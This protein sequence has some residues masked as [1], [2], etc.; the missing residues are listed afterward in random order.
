[1]TA[2]EEATDPHLLGSYIRRVY[3]LRYLWLHVLVVGVSLVLSFYSADTWWSR[4]VLVLAQYVFLLAFG[5]Y[6]WT[7]WVMLRRPDQPRLLPSVA[8]ITVCFAF[9]LTL[10]IAATPSP[11][12][13]YWWLGVVWTIVGFPTLFV[14]FKLLRSVRNTRVGIQNAWSKPRSNE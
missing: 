13:P 1:M 2:Q 9:A 8:F 11:L 3:R 5:L 12:Q 4:V 10:T 14:F 6:A 7:G